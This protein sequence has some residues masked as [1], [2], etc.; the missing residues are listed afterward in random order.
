MSEYEVELDFLADKGGPYRVR[1]PAERIKR[2]LEGGGQ[3]LL[4]PIDDED[5]EQTY[6]A[7]DRRISQFREVNALTHKQMASRIESLEKRVIGGDFDDRLKALEERPGTTV[8]WSSHVE[9]QFNGVNYRLNQLEIFQGIAKRAITGLLSVVDSLIAPYG[10][11]LLQRER[12]ACDTLRAIRND[13]DPKTGGT[14]GEATGADGPERHGP[15]GE[16]PD[17]AYRIL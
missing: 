4:V 6:Q 12:Q 3:A 9:T 7:L 11:S 1:V 5:H 13:I 10:R 14:R 17:Q 2:V 8:V 16:V 15:R